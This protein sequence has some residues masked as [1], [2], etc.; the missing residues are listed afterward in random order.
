MKTLKLTLCLLLVI[1]FSCICMGQSK[2]KK[3]KMDEAISS[4]KQTDFIKAYIKQAHAIDSL[5]TYFQIRKEEFNP[6]EVALL[7]AHH[8]DSLEDFN[9]LLDKLKIDLLNKEDRRYLIKHPE[10]YATNFEGLL[11]KAGKSF[12]NN[13]AYTMEHMLDVDVAAF[14]LMEF[15]IFMGLIKEVVGMVGEIG[16][17]LKKNDTEYLENNLLKDLRLK[18][19]DEY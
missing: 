3:K 11:E 2:A 6:E 18:Q 13:C 16:N 17:K 7:K 14:G 15:G 8:E 4:L 9:E 10:A 19:W 1:S 5:V 12:D